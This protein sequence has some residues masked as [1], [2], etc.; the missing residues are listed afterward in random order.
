[1]KSILLTSV[2][3]AKEYGYVATIDITNFFIQTYIDSKPE[4]EKI[5][6]KIN[7]V[8]V[9]NLV[10]MDTG[11]YYPAVVYERVN[12][13]LY[14]EFLKY[15]YGMLQSAML[16]SNKMEKYLKIDGSKLKPYDPCVAN[17]IVEVE[18]RTVVF[19]LDYVKASRKGEMW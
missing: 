18:S 4:E 15:I 3:D 12:K 2:I 17:M 19:R 7:G 5:T 1:M 10:H 9:D 6:M 14:I 8:M 11:K 16:S 13:V